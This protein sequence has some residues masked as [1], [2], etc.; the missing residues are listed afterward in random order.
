MPDISGIFMESESRVSSCF[1]RPIISAGDIVKVSLWSAPVCD[2]I[3][4]SAYGP[5]TGLEALRAACEASDIPVYALGGIT[6]ERIEELSDTEIAGVA[7]IGS[8]FGA[9]SPADATRTLL[10]ALSD[11]LK[12]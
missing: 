1:A 5:A 6:P 4:K 2:P 12:P 3:S 7:A 8:V 11:H 9:A 10:Q